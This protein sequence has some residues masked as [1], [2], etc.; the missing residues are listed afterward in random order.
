MR[1]DAVKEL[2]LPT[3]AD[4]STKGA[5]PEKVDLPAATPKKLEGPAESAFI[6]SE[7]LPVVPAKLVKRI[8]KAEYVDMAELLKD[9]MEAE[10]RRMLSDSAFPQSHLTNRPVRREIPDMLSWL[11][12]FSLYAAVV[13]SKYPEKARELW[14]YQATLIGEARRCGGRGWLLYDSA[15]RQQITS[16]DAVDFS[17]I[18]QSLYSTTFLAYG[19]GAK[20]CPE[21]MM[22]DHSQE[23]CALHPNRSLPV[24]QMQ[25]VRRGGREEP[26][27]RPPEG[28]KRRAGRRGPCFQWNDGRCTHPYCRFEHVCSRCYGDHKR[29]AC[30]IGGGEMNQKKE[31]GGP[32][33]HTH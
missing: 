32:K 4:L 21:C 6:L 25:E 13:A 15:F 20:F 10:R 3:F 28:Y 22:A 29:V 14:A 18:N 24:V 30:K 5:E 1:P 11:Q 33:L 23:E 26:R 27:L 9:N 16:F 7:A 17:K 19:A 2:N 8:Q 31:G 12:C